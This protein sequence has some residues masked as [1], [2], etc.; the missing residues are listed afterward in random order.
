MGSKDREGAATS[1]SSLMGAIV[2]GVLIAVIPAALGYIASFIDGARKDELAFVNQQIEKLY[3]PL[4][5]LT[6]A[7]DVTWRQ[8]ASTNW[9]NNSRYYFD[10]QQPPSEEQVT[11]WRLWMRTVF[12]PLNVH[13][14]STIVNNSQLIVGNRIPRSFQELIAQTEAYKAI[15]AGWSDHDKDNLETY[16][17]RYKNTV[18]GLNYPDSIV[19]CVSKTYDALK[20]RQTELQSFPNFLGNFLWHSPLESDSTCNK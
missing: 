20:R 6:Q 4:L 1:G 12:Q 14:E 8:F 11:E 2:A 13:I 15:I 16:R 3:G 9:P 18:T 7:N 10:P 17:S 19:E 5:A